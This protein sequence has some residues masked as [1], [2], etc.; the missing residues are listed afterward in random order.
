MFERILHST[1]PLYMIHFQSIFEQLWKE[2]I[3]AQDRIRQ[4]ETGFA[5]V[6]TKV[7]EN[8]IQSKNLFLQIIEEA[9]DEVMVIF[10][11][12]NT[13]KNQSKIG[14]FNLLKLKNQQNFRIRILSPSIDTVKEI[15]LLEYSN[16]RY[17]TIDNIMIREIP[18][19]Q[20]FRSTILMVDKKH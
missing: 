6:T 19:Q 10:P 9:Q 14:L 13:I 12:L 17:T 8:P 2:G 20:E 7:F 3:N 18:K 5:A 4:I 11:S 1:E 15:L 16:E